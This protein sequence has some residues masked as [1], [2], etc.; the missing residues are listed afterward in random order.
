MLDIFGMLPTGHTNISTFS[1]MEQRPNRH[2]WIGNLC[3]NVREEEI[4]DLFQRHGRIQSVKLLEEVNSNNGGRPGKSATIAF[5]DI[6]S[7][8][9]ALRNVRTVAGQPIHI[10]YYEPGSAPPPSFPPHNS[11]GEASVNSSETLVSP[12]QGN[13]SS[14]ATTNNNVVVTNNCIP[15]TPGPGMYRQQRFSGGLHGQ[16]ED[17]SSHFY[18]QPKSFR[19]GRGDEGFH[20]SRG[21]RENRPPFHSRHSFPADNRNYRSQWNYHHPEGRYAPPVHADEERPSIPSPVVHTPPSESGPNKPP[22]RAESPASSVSSRHL[23]SKRRRSRS[24]SNSGSS[25]RGSSVGSRS[26]SGSRSSVSTSVSSSRSR[27]PS[28]HGNFPRSTGSNNN[29][30][31]DRF[32]HSS[33]SRHRNAGGSQHHNNHHHHRRA[34]SV[35][36]LAAIKIRNLPIRSSDTSLKDGLYHEYKKHGKVAWVRVNGTGPDR[37]AIV[38]FK[39][40]EH[41]TRAVSVS[42]G[43]LF[44]GCKIQVT[45]YKHAKG[46]DII[47]GQD[48]ENRLLVEDEPT[49]V[50][51]PTRTVLITGLD[52][53]VT[54]AELQAVFDQYGDIVRL[55][56]RKQGTATHAVCEFVDIA[57]AIR[58]QWGRH[59]FKSKEARISFFRN[60]PSNALILDGT[61]GVNEKQVYGQCC[62]YGAIKEIVMDPERVLAVVQFQ[63][64]SEAQTAIRQLRSWVIKGKR[65]QVDFA[66]ND[67]IRRV[68]Q[69][70]TGVT[71]SPAGNSSPGLIS[72]PSIGN[73][74]IPLHDTINIGRKMSKQEEED[75]DDND[76]IYNIP[77]DSDSY[78]R[79]SKT[80]RNLRRIV[81]SSKSQ[82][83]SINSEMD[84]TVGYA[85]DRAPYSIRPYTSPVSPDADHSS[86]LAG[87]QAP[88]SS[89]RSSNSTSKIDFNCHETDSAVVTSSSDIV[90]GDKSEVHS[91]SGM[92]FDD[93]LGYTESEVH[94]SLDTSHGALTFVDGVSSTSPE[95]KPETVRKAS[96][97]S[98][99]S[100]S[101][102]SRSSSIESRS[103]FKGVVDPRRQPN[104]LKIRRSS[105]DSG[106]NVGTVSSYMH[107]TSS[108]ITNTTSHP[109]ASTT[110]NNTQVV[111]EESDDR[112]GTPLCDENPES[113]SSSSEVPA[114]TPSSKSLSFTLNTKMDPI[115]LPLPEFALQSQRHRTNSNTSSSKEF[116]S[117][118]VRVDRCSIE[119]DSNK[120]PVMSP[121]LH[122]TNSPTEIEVDTASSLVSMDEATVSPTTSNSVWKDESDQITSPNVPGG[123]SN[124]SPPTCEESPLH[125]FEEKH[126][127]ANSVPDSASLNQDKIIGSPE[128]DDTGMSPKNSPTDSVSLEQ[129]ILKCCETYDRF[130]GGKALTSES[131]DVFNDSSPACVISHTLKSGS[132]TDSSSDSPSSRF[133]FLDWTE[134][135]QRPSDIGKSVLAR[136]SVFDED[137]KRLENFEEKYEA[138]G[139]STP[140]SSTTWRAIALQR[141]LSVSSSS[142]SNNWHFPHTPVP[143]ASSSSSPSNSHP[144]H[145]PASLVGTT[146]TSSIRSHDRVSVIPTSLNNFNPKLTPS[147]SASVFQSSAQP[148]PKDLH[149]LSSSSITSSKPVKLEAVPTTKS[150]PP[151]SP[152]I[153]SQPSLQTTT[154]PHKLT[155]PKANIEPPKSPSAKTSDVKDANE[156][157]QAVINSSIPPITSVTP[158]AHVTLREE[159][160]SLEK[161]SSAVF[162]SPLTIPRS[163]ERSISLDSNKKVTTNNP[164]SWGQ[165]PIVTTLA[166]S[167]NESSKGAHRRSSI[168]SSSSLTPKSKSLLQSGET[169]GLSSTKVKSEVFTTCS[170]STSS[171]SSTAS[172]V[173]TDNKISKELHKPD[174]ELLK[175]DIS[176]IRPIHQ[177]TTVGVVAAEQITFIPSRS[178][179]VS[180]T[181][182]RD[183]SSRK[184]K[185]KKRRSS[186]TSPPVSSLP[187]PSNTLLHVTRPETLQPT[188]TPHQASSRDNISS[189]KKVD[190]KKEKKDRGS[191]S[192]LSS[193][194][195]STST[196]NAEQLDKDDGSR[197]SGDN[198]KDKDK[199]DCKKEKHSSH[200][201]STTEHSRSSLNESSHHHHRRDKEPSTSTKR[202]R[203][204]SGNEGEREM[205]QKKGKLEK[206]VVHDVTLHRLKAA[207]TNE[208]RES[209]DSSSSNKDRHKETSSKDGSSRASSSS[210]SLPA[211][212]ALKDNKKEDSKTKENHYRS[213]KEKSSNSKDRHYDKTRTSSENRSSVHQPSKS[214]YSSNKDKDRSKKDRG[215]SPGK[216]NVKGSSSS[217]SRHHTHSSSSHRSSTSSKKE[218]T[219]ST[220]SKPSTG[221]DDKIKRSHTDKHNNSIDSDSCCEYNSTTTTAKCE[222]SDSQSR[223]KCSKSQSKSSRSDKSRDSNEKWERHRSGDSTTHA[224]T[225]GAGGDSDRKKNRDQKKKKKFVVEET[226]SDS[227]SDDEDKKKHHSIFE[228]VIDEYVSMY[229][230]VKARSNRACKAQPHQPQVVDEVKKKEDKI[231]DQFR[232][233]K[234]SRAKKIEKKRSTSVDESNKS[235][236]HTSSDEETLRMPSTDASTHVHS[237]LSHDIN[238]EHNLRHTSDEEEQEDEDEDTHNESSRS[239]SSKKMKSKKKSS[240]EK[241][242]KRRGKKLGKSPPK[243]YQRS[244]ESVFTNSECE[245]NASSHTA[246]PQRKKKKITTSKLSFPDVNVSQELKSSGDSMSDSGS[247]ID[248]SPKHNK[249]VDT[250]KPLGKLQTIDVYSSD[251]DSSVQSGPIRRPTPP[252]IKSSSGKSKSKEKLSKQKSMK[253]SLFSSD[254]SEEDKRPPPPPP[255]PAHDVTRKDKKEAQR[256]KS[257]ER[258]ESNKSSHKKHR[259]HSSVSKSGKSGKNRVGSGD[260]SVEIDSASLPIIGKRES[261]ST[262]KDILFGPMSASSGSENEDQVLH[263]S[264]HAPPARPKTPTIAAHESPPRKM[265]DIIVHSP[266]KTKPIPPADE[267]KYPRSISPCSSSL[268]LQTGLQTSDNLDLEKLDSKLPPEKNNSERRHRRHHKDKKSKRTDSDEQHHSNTKN[269]SKSGTSSETSSVNTK[270]DLDSLF[271]SPRVS[272]CK[273]YMSPR[274]KQESISETPS[275]QFLENQIATS[276]PI[277][278]NFESLSVTGE[279]T[280]S[281]FSSDED[282]DDDKLKIDINEA[283]IASSDEPG[284]DI[285][286]NLISNDKRIR[287]ELFEQDK[288]IESIVLLDRK[289]PP[290]TCPVPDD[291][292][293]KY[294]PKDGTAISQEETEDAVAA[295]LETLEGDDSIEETGPIKQ[296]SAVVTTATST[297][298]VTPSVSSPPTLRIIEEQAPPFVS[299]SEV[300]VLAPPSVE[301]KQRI[302]SPIA[303]SSLEHPPSLA[304]MSIDN[305]KGEKPNIQTTPEAIVSRKSSLDSISG[306]TEEVKIISQELPSPSVPLRRTS[307]STKSRQGSSERDN[308]ENNENS[309]ADIY[310][311]HDSDDETSDKKKGLVPHAKLSPITVLDLAIKSPLSSP[312]V[313]V[314]NSE[315][316]SPLVSPNSTSAAVGGHSPALPSL[317]VTTDQQQINVASSSSVVVPPPPTV[318]P[319]TVIT[320]KPFTPITPVSADPFMIR[321]TIMTPP[322][323]SGSKTPPAPCPLPPPI[324]NKVD[325]TI[326]H[327]IRMAVQSEDAFFCAPPVSSADNVVTIT[328]IKATARGR[329][330]SRDSGTEETSNSS[331]NG[332]SGP[333][334]ITRVS[335]RPETVISTTPPHLPSTS[336]S[337][338]VSTGPTSAHHHPAVDTPAQVIKCE[339][340]AG[341]LLKDDAT[342]TL[343]DPQ[344]GILMPMIR[345]SEEGQYVPILGQESSNLGGLP[346]V[347]QPQFSVPCFQKEHDVIVPKSEEK[348]QIVNPPSNIQKSE[349][350]AATMFSHPQVFQMPGQNQ[351]V[352]PQNVAG[353]KVI[354]HQPRF[355]SVMP[356]H[357]LALPPESSA[358]TIYMT[359]PPTQ[360]TGP[361]NLPQIPTHTGMRMPSSSNNNNNNSTGRS[362]QEFGHKGVSHDS[363]PVSI[364]HLGAG[365]MIRAIFP[366]GVPQLLQ[367]GQYQYAVISK[368]EL[369]P[370]QSSRLQGSNLH[371]QQQIPPMMQNI[372][373]YGA[374]NVSHGQGE[375]KNFQIPSATTIT[376]VNTGQEEAMQRKNIIMTSQPSI[377]L[378]SPVTSLRSVSPNVMNAKTYMSATPSMSMTRQQQQQHHAQTELFHKSAEGLIRVAPKDEQ[379]IHGVKNMHSVPQEI[380]QPPRVE[381]NV[382]AHA[383]ASAQSPKGRITGHDQYQSMSSSM[384]QYTLKSG[385]VRILPTPNTSIPDH[386]H[387]SFIQ[388]REYTNYNAGSPPTS[389]HGPIMRSGGVGGMP[390]KTDFNKLNPMMAAHERNRMAAQQNMQHSMSPHSMEQRNSESPVVSSM[391]APS[392][393]GK[394][395]MYQPPTPAHQLQGVPRQ[396]NFKNVYADQMER[397]QHANSPS[398][399]PSFDPRV[400]VPNMVPPDRER[401]LSP[402]S[403]REGVL[404]QRAPY[405][406]PPAHGRYSI[407]PSQGAE[408][409]N[410]ERQQRIMN[411]QTPPHMISQVPPQGDTLLMLLQ[412]YPIMWQGLLTLKNDNAACQMHFVSG[413]LDVARESLPANPDGSVP[414]LRI[415]QRM[416][417]EEAQ[418]QGVA[419]KM[420]MEPEHCIL[421]ALPCGRDQVDVL[422]QSNN[423]RHGFITY[424]QLKQAAGIINIGHQ[425]QATFVIHIFPSCDFANENLARIA[426]DLLHGVADIAH[427]L[428][429]IATV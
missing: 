291:D 4:R 372:A 395:P 220:S 333:V 111:D 304:S 413:N 362:S 267:R 240:M 46:E 368:A 206:E 326:E 224:S 263:S 5:I 378:S 393:H 26:R 339:I 40:A 131:S 235:G 79:V 336:P 159:V 331:S 193:G 95:P 278:N 270:P 229:D 274:I 60:P 279:V 364:S 20:G 305:N 81:P 310:E 17:S 182:T 248:E 252:V 80:D 189:V 217:S 410:N 153:T 22:R 282:D 165:A 428:I 379:Q 417:L 251:S 129:R 272:P 109:P 139:S 388:Q 14:N 403:I 118:S 130:N 6:R 338:V 28:H 98:A 174:L 375:I 335:H 380:V 142:S 132:S 347:Q 311:F 421:L 386:H 354:P 122:V 318:A 146:T 392:V 119:S 196:T 102:S 299:T 302:T 260:G 1:W 85:S 117:S 52:A 150:H 39:S 75:D 301:N 394:Q 51:Y 86:S 49:S 238:R 290:V 319:P 56:I 298:V 418:L 187:P 330:R 265:S 113:F 137:S 348:P 316:K 416:R 329:S 88:N 180:S 181:S 323:A 234:Q 284:M 332:G 262:M 97:D 178:D 296:P 101:I 64:I 134:L 371:Q 324:R 24:V 144:I 218:S 396:D 312:P 357:R 69:R 41:A 176:G 107:S 409:H 210:I 73:S 70:V 62:Q 268:D 261:T 54:S 31:T 287:E 100:H 128:S 381:I 92:N 215:V 77:E 195:T 328:S 63:E 143:G 209:R 114:V 84:G 360:Y 406:P 245:S 397:Q 37:F 314:T 341:Q 285:R 87:Q 89:V 18:D 140:T 222:N 66:S 35:E 412:R 47:G 169:S 158:L 415:S 94:G 198:N 352:I 126:L 127:S 353:A 308:D 2:L 204:N 300:N 295:L 351:Y 253:K 72:S 161:A 171:L 154:V 266:R 327:V 233:L 105:A 208:R 93:K 404:Q 425:N 342:E 367:S 184:E 12:S 255:P 32:H 83:A 398:Y 239:K 186:G 242:L 363:I 241:L 103:F 197:K 321:P 390:E 385:E 115:S 377:M 59:V 356:G 407:P 361:N 221:H 192:K 359:K 25:D 23:I 373:K 309:S 399:P 16:S 350:L 269:Y 213:S 108:S 167:D 34:S 78:I 55:D 191:E 382:N 21:R 322:L 423:L 225:S 145:I 136:K 231:K 226:D 99:V 219:S 376:K 202:K 166:V 11:H 384:P 164:R 264:D 306:N 294:D 91:N 179:S 67:V 317:S 188:T 277:K 320:P 247:A 53:T 190:D 199:R 216:E 315:A 273:E 45:P 124:D 281:M 38:C 424:L 369:P 168:D 162:S 96:P 283:I 120:S 275:T 230:K 110:D 214:D 116:P 286:D 365:P 340:E 48:E 141:S 408:G 30:T 346:K 400:G 244:M 156:R 152:H 337:S 68:V 13:P 185:E 157:C 212:V 401:V 420:Q 289:S 374:P 183:S 243:S 7:A 405:S 389:S 104:N 414:P 133:K 402:Y 271:N 207:S 303:W 170:V 228:V 121:S 151:S 429:V 259:G 297:S 27:S 194:N 325:D 344:T 10:S 15:S 383:V 293:V 427:L 44:F 42:Q 148:K 172:L 71:P 422:Q 61:A 387:L 57:S 203:D 355:Q 334:S 256:S 135:M 426:P 370:T 50:G 160:S 177:E 232:A 9:K 125:E 249:K 3:E 250:V 112:P 58:A 147:L 223:S 258:G 349:G 175:R 163:V 343:I 345:Q 280:R 200:K 358:A 65:L 254:S 288:A 149:T 366:P 90:V 8:S 76:G 419:T 276:S 29:N 391:Y 246:E 138:K 236:V 155:F 173:T 43:K 307:C 211:E 82:L 292:P 205:E 411:A 36:L 257:R 237:E 33:H 201:D 227:D 313:T 106:N 74:V 123:H 19:G